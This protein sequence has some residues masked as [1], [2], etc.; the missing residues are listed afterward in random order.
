MELKQNT[1]KLCKPIYCKIK[2]LD[3]YKYD[4]NDIQ[5]TLLKPIFEHAL[6]LILMDTNSFVF[7]IISM[8]KTTYNETILKIQ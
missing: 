5:Y 4:I 2:I 6:T 1:I 3:L 8:H 7:S